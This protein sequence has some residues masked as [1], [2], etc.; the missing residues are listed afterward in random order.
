MKYLCVLLSLFLVACDSDDKVE[1]P[2]CSVD[3][4]YNVGIDPNDPEVTVTTFIVNNCSP[5]IDLVKE[6][7]SEQ[8]PEQEVTYS[9]GYTTSDY[10][11]HRY[12]DSDD[13]TIHYATT[14]NRLDI[15][16]ATVKNENN[17]ITD[18]YQLTS[19]DTVDDD[20]GDLT[21]LLGSTVTE[22]EAVRYLIDNDSDFFKEAMRFAE[23][24]VSEE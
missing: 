14:D 17:V 21:T 22:F 3:N 4:T 2:H 20:I 15:V 7:E 6:Y 16:Y 18:E 12:L 9:V 24:E 23:E 11:Y 19:S 5:K 10:Y 1:H 13:G 8:G